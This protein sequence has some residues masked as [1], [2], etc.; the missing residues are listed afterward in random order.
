[1]NETDIPEFIKKHSD[2]IKQNKMGYGRYIW[3]PKIILDT[4]LKTNENDI[5]LYCDAGCYLNNKGNYGYGNAKSVVFSSDS[6]ISLLGRIIRY[7]LVQTN[8]N[9]NINDRSGWT[10]N[11][12]NYGDNKWKAHMELVSSSSIKDPNNINVYDLTCDHVITRQSFKK[13]EIGYEPI[14]VARYMRNRANHKIMNV[15]MAIYP[16]E[17]RPVTHWI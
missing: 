4:L 8:G 3:K 12:N 10:A 6:D 17:G 9:I 11:V 14:L 1:M 15:R 2:F 5:I 13:F 16:K 7:L